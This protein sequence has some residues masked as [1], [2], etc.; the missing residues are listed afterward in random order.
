MGIKKRETERYSGYLEAPKTNVKEE[1]VEDY[2]RN[3]QGF[4]V[5]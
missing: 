5:C 4:A 2:I 3:H 1:E